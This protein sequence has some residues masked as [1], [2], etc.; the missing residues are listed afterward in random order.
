MNSNATDHISHTGHFD[1][2]LCEVP[3]HE[4]DDTIEAG[5]LVWMRP[6]ETTPSSFAT[7]GDCAKR[8]LLGGAK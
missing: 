2:V 3:C 8:E 6:G 5:D 7:C 4:C 1:M